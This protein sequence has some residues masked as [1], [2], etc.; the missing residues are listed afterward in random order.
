MFRE[1]IVY[2]NTVERKCWNLREGHYTATIATYII[3]KTKW[4]WWK[5]YEIRQIV[6][7]ISEPYYDGE[8]ATNNNLQSAADYERKVAELAITLLKNGQNIDDIRN[9]DNP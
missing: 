2:H 7:Y 5:K 6:P 8:Y 4:W 3:E 1:R 9:N